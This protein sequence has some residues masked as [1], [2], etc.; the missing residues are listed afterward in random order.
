MTE[1]TPE[2]GPGSGPEAGEVRLRGLPVSPGIAV[3]RVYLIGLPV[4]EKGRTAIKP[5]EIE[6]ELA[7]MR[8]AVEELSGELER[9]ADAATGPEQGILRAHLMLL[10]DPA[11]LGEIERRIAEG[12]QS[13]GAS[14]LDVIATYE[15]M[16]ERFDDHMIR[17]RALDIK[18]VCI[19]LLNVHV[20]RCQRT[21]LTPDEPIIVAARELLPS[22]TARLDRGKLLGIV[23]ERGGMTSHT[24]ILARSFGIPAVCGVP[25]LLPALHPAAMVVIDGTTGDVVVDP[26]DATI[27]RYRAR[28]DALAAERLAV[29][30]VDRGP[31]AT[32][33]GTPIQVLANINRPDDL[34]LDSMGLAEG[35]GLFRTEYYFMTSRRLPSEEEQYQQYRDVLERADGREVIIRTVDA[36]GDKAIHYLDP[37]H[38]DNPMMGSRSIRL[39]LRK[40]EV[41][42]PQIRAILR[43]A[44][45][46]EARL[47]FPLVSTRSELEAATALVA[48]ARES[49]RNDGVEHR[50]DV[51]IGLLI[52]VPAAA[53]N[54]ESLLPLLDFVSVGTNDLTQFTL[55]VDRGN[56]AVSHLYQPLHPAVLRL[57]AHVARVARSTGTPVSM[58]GE[59]A[60]DPDH[61]ALLIGLGYRRLSV[62]PY[63]LPELRRRISRID[64]SA[65]RR[66]AARAL[67]SGSNREIK[68]LLEA[69]NRRLTGSGS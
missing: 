66:L 4:G 65:A 15:S 14:I 23:S 2:T 64:L 58:C 57:L 43:A 59:M 1:S 37:G 9:L 30:P 50:S 5:G 51:P 3:G 36:G 55:A 39:C 10:E 28:R 6:A 38:E 34:A 31:L 33:D 68:S 45:H 52:E 29:E 20:D 63:L 8:A 22:Q 44:M 18:D 53:L 24:A 17:E 46:G 40:P 7:A 21:L 54:L 19:Q 62:S 60:S 67:R 69:E 48:Q 11:L 25:D 35:V 12:Q 42:L 56:P 16:F 61:A 32:A 26:D 41:I 27:E 13:L 47:M 49:L